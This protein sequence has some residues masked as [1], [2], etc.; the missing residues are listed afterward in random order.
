MTYLGG[1]FYS[2]AMLPDWAQA[3]SKANPILYMVNAFRYGFLGHSD[4]N[5]GLSF[6]LMVVAAAL[7]FGVCVWLMEKGTGTRE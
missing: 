5:L 2:I 3:V 4:V 6:T 1:V 7:L